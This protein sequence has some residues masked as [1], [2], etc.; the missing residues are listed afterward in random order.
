MSRAA[1][2]R[3]G[4]ETISGSSTLSVVTRAFEECALTFTGQGGRIASLAGELRAACSPLADPSVGGA[5]GETLGQQAVA[6]AGSVQ[7]VGED[8]CTGIV[9]TLQRLLAG[10]QEV[11]GAQAAHPHLVILPSDG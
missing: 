3:G 2:G 11:D 4:G 9:Q 10:F 8:G 1:P 5:H 6:L 7:A